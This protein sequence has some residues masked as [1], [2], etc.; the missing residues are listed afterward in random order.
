MELW[1][2]T[3]EEMTKINAEIETTRTR[4]NDLSDELAT[5]QEDV[6]E[7]VMGNNPA[8]YK[9]LQQRF[10]DASDELNFEKAKLELLK[11]EKVE[12]AATIE[13]E[14][15]AEIKASIE[16]FKPIYFEQVEKVKQLRNEHRDALVELEQMERQA[17]RQIDSNYFG[18]RKAA[19]LSEEGRQDKY[20]SGANFVFKNML[21]NNGMYASGTMHDGLAY[22]ERMLKSIIAKA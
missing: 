8:E 3:N 20:R 13:P 22:D 18:Q 16:R 11:G 9:K 4:I 6:K 5:V 17:K 12:L 14:I 19:G 10:R 1:K 7:S 15:E 21:I 2:Y